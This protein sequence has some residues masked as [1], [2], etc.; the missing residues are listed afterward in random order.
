[1]PYLLWSMACHCRCT[2][3]DSPATVSHVEKLRALPR[4]E[5]VPL[6]AAGD[7]D[8]LEAVVVERFAGES[9][10]ES[11]QPKASDVEKA[12]PFVLGCPPERTRSTT[13]QGDV[14]PVV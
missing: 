6:A 9:A 12:Q 14:D 1:M 13:V 8:V 7:E 5:G 11:F 4:P 3:V 10:V 2:T